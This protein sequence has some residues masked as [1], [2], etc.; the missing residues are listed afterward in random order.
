MRAFRPRPETA[1][2]PAWA[3]GLP[4]RLARLLFDTLA[5]PGAAFAGARATA[6]ARRLRFQSN[7]CELDVLLENEGDRLRLTAQLLSTGPVI[8]P[9]AAARFVVNVGGR[10]AAEGETD[11]DGELACTASAGGEVEI[12]L[13]AAGELLVFRIPGR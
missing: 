3:R 2:G 10:I 13:A 8:A 5:S 7:G 11:G 9:I 1:P 12:R 4:E 6:A